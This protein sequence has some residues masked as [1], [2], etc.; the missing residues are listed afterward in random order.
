VP[1][2][3]PTSLWR[4]LKTSFRD[5][6]VRGQDLTVY[7]P[8]R[9]I[10]RRVGAWLRHIG[11]LGGG[12]KPTFDLLEDSSVIG[13][14][15][16]RGSRA[17]WVCSVC[18]GSLVLGAAGLLR[19]LPCRC[20]LECSRGTAC[21][22]GIFGIGDIAGN[23]S[24]P[25]VVGVRC[26]AG[27]VNRSGGD[28][29]EEQDVV[30]DQ[31]PDRVHLDAQ[32]IGRRQAFPVWALRNVDHRVCRSLRGG[33]DAVFMDDVGDGASAHFMS[34]I[35]E[36]AADPCVSPRGIFERHAQNEIDDRLHEARAARSTPLAVVPF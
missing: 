23:L 16:D 7:G 9:F 34:Q 15:A 4:Y 24:H 6:L 1:V 35:G 26:D 11:P 18:T 31:S 20:V 30:R 8:T 14:L 29:D 32:E 19:G 28:V 27:D 13:F 36:R 3:G 17:R 33:P 10:S 25:A 5:C 12:A 21:R 2:R 22:K